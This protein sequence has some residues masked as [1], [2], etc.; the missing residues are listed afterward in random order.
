MAALQCEIATTER[1]FP[2]DYTKC[3]TITQ[4]LSLVDSS[5]ANFGQCSAIWF[6]DKKSATRDLGVARW[7]T[8]FCTALTQ[9]P[10]FCGLLHL[11]PYEPNKAGNQYRYGRVAV[12]YHDRNDPGATFVMADTKSTLADVVPS[13]VDR[14]KQRIWPRS[15]SSIL[16]LMSPEPLP[17]ATTEPGDETRSPCQLQVTRFACGGIAISL[18]LHHA[19]AD[20]HTLL[21]FASLIANAMRG[22]QGNEA[23]LLRFQPGKL[24]ARAAGDIDEAEADERVQSK[25]IS[26]PLLRGDW[27]A[28]G[29]RTP[30][31]VKGAPEAIADREDVK[32]PSGEAM[33][34]ADWDTSAQVGHT[35]I[36]FTAE[37]VET[38]YAMASADP[39]IGFVSHHDALLAHVWIA[40][41][42]ARKRAYHGSEAALVRHDV[43]HANT[44]LSLR[45]VSRLDLGEDFAGSP[46]QIADVALSLSA[47]TDHPGRTLSTVASTFRK[48]LASLDSETLRAQLHSLAYEASP[49]RIWQAFLG[50]K[51]VIFTS[52]V[53]ESAYEIDFGVG[54]PMWM[55]SVMDDLDGIVVLCE[56]TPLP[57]QA[58]ISE[59]EKKWWRHGVD[60]SIHLESK[61]LAELIVNVSFL[62]RD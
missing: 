7:R 47:L 62:M 56:G 19:L 52:W 21:R 59:G 8:A 33:Q 38:V 61:A 15:S 18:K 36:H 23:N 37:H 60:V 31:W 14:R 53:K 24:D 57:G 27:Y 44:S 16:P 45:P 5:V 2:H 54:E 29:H 58:K 39:A 43:M 17:K 11:S 12:H 35:V 50:R 46:I 3:R 40:I 25:A 10:H 49:Q 4:Q 51:H 20:A 32:T 42:Q 6:F 28:S 22:S 1:V 34:F 9:C 41:V 55:E 13:V 30:S 48:T 26:A